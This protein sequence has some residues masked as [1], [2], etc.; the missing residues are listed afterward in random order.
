MA[1]GSEEHALAFSEDKIRAAQVI[2]DVVALPET[3]PLINCAREMNKTVIT[4][5]E[6]F[7]IQAVEQFALYTGIRPSDELFKQA[8]AYSR[9]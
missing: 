7:A 8:A 9:Q 6:V 2:F 1:G 3:T 5:S 4:G